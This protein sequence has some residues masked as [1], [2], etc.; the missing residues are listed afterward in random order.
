LEVQLWY[1][2]LIPPIAVVIRNTC[3]KKMNLVAY[4]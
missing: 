3:F 1:G 2:L 4:I